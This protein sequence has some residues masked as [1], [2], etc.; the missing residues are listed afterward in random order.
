[1]QNSNNYMLNNVSSTH[2]SDFWCQ[3]GNDCIF[4]FNT[5]YVKFTCFTDFILELNLTHKAIK[6]ITVSYMQDHGDRE[7][8]AG[9]PEVNWVGQDKIT[10]FLLV[11]Y[12]NFGTHTSSG[13]T[14]MNQVERKKF[15]YN[16]SFLDEKS[17]T[18]W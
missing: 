16:L 12:D 8:Q 4:I 1:M 17:F 6:G 7:K 2:N 13:L 15:T 14:I 10:S 11:S 18:F 9:Q 3:I 5:E